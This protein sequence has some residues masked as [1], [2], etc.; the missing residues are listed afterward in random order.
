LGEACTPKSGDERFGLPAIQ[1]LEGKGRAA[2][3]RLE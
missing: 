2:Q 1:D 3:G